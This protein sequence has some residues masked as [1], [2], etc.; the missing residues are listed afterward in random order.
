M[1]VVFTEL[2]DGR[3]EGE[4]ESYI[5]RLFGIIPIPGVKPHRGE[6]VLVNGRLQTIACIR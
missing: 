5:F 6:T 3:T 4:V 2:V 1:T